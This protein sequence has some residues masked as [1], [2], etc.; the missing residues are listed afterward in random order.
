MARNETEREDFLREAVGLEPRGELR[1]E[2]LPELLTVGYRTGGALS[3]YF[4][5]DPV[6]QFDGAGRLRRAF[7][8]GLLFRSERGTL[9]R[10]RRERTEDAVLLVRHDL[11]SGELAEFRERMLQ[12]LGKL[13]RTLELNA[14]EVVRSM[15]DGPD[16]PDWR[17]L[18]LPNL[19]LI[20]GADPWMAGPIVG[21][22]LGK[23][24]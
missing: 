16:A 20:A 6:Y 21:R 19:L 14:Y 12:L 1:C 3:V 15:P 11:E 13:H 24:G 7:V 8:E 22:K 2:G 4:G 23:I 10:L 17:G 18:L 5:Q 9:A